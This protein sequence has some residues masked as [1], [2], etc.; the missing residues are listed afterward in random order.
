MS[1]ILIIISIILAPIAMMAIIFTGALFVGL[2]KGFI[3][4]MQKQKNENSEKLKKQ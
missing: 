2:I 3:K 1:V 4:A